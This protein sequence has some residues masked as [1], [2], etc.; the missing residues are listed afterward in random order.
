MPRAAEGREDRGGVQGE[1]DALRP[2]DVVSLAQPG[3]DPHRLADLVHE[4]PPGRAG[5]VAVHHEA[6][7]VRAHVDDRHA[8]HARHHRLCGRR[9]R[10]PSM[11]PLR[12]LNEPHGAADSD[13]DERDRPRPRPVHHRPAARQPPRAR[14]PDRPGRRRSRRGPD[15]VRGRRAPSG[16][17]SARD[18]VGS[19]LYL[20][21]PPGRST[22]TSPASR[23]A[24]RRSASASCGCASSAP[25]AAR[26]A[27]ARSRSA[28]S[29]AWSTESA[30]TWSASW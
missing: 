17:G 6:P 12:G 29:C 22:T 13:E 30:C 24:V 16:S 28:P 8:F 3:A 9:R 10:A 11:W 2:K 1:L 14:R 23:A 27:W 21:G 7:G 20:L 19:G 18:E 15:P 5:L 26:R 4:A 25:T